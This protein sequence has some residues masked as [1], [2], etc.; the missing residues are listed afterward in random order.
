MFIID[1]WKIG[2]WCANLSVSVPDLMT[3]SGEFVRMLSMHVFVQFGC[4][5][6]AI[7]IRG[8]YPDEMTISSYS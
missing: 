2:E 1:I 4:E 3:E 6:V 8:Q 5:C 7:D